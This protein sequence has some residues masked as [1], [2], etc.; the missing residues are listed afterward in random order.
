MSSANSH[1][2]LHPARLK[3]HY[4][5]E[6]RE[7]MLIQGSRS[8]ENI[9]RK[10][11]PFYCILRAT[12]SSHHQ[13]LSALPAWLYWPLDCKG[14]CLI[15]FLGWDN[16]LESWIFWR[17]ISRSGLDRERAVP[18]WLHHFWFSI[19]TRVFDIVDSI[20]SCGYYTNAAWTQ[21]MQAHTI[22]RTAEATA[23]ALLKRVFDTSI[24]VAQNLWNYSQ[25]FHMGPSSHTVIHSESPLSLNSISDLHGTSVSTHFEG[26]VQITACKTHSTNILFLW[27]LMPL[28][29]CLFQHPLKHCLFQH[30]F[31]V[32]TH[33][34]E[35]KRRE[36][37]LQLQH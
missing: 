36:N 18:L 11:N 19:S 27:S 28:K 5:Q 7:S 32:Q 16:N 31:I 35:E 26:V 2:S 25:P 21:T 10:R 17:V 9:A 33:A 20:T 1:T 4:S 15:S 23:L 24:Q 29:H 6:G 30:P 22:R 3:N 37:Q 12:H 34:H 14:S 13:P 8:N